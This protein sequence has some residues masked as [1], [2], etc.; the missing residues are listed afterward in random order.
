ME[1]ILVMSLSGSTMTLVYLLV[2][3]LL[4]KRIPARVHYLLAKIAV[5]YYLI[6]LP[7]LKSRY[8]EFFNAVMPG[9]QTVMR[10]IPLR[11]TNYFVRGEEKLYLNIYAKIQFVA[12]AV[13]LLVICYLL[14]GEIREYLHAIRRFVKY[15]NKDMTESQTAFVESL[16]EAYRIRRRI[17]VCQGENGESTMTFGIFRP[18]IFCGR[19]LETRE[20]E[21]L[22]RHELVH[23]K[24]RDVL[25]KILIRFAKLLHWWNPIMWALY[26]DFE[27]VSEWACDETVMADKSE[28]E[29]KEYLRL[30]I[31]ESRDDGEP[32]E[33][34]LRWRAGFGED[35]KQLMERM[36]NLMSRKK[37]NRIAAGMLVTVLAFANSMTVFAYRDTYQRELPDGTSQEEIEKTLNKDSIIFLPDEMSLEETP[38][39][40]ILEELEIVYDRQ[41]ID[42][43]GNIYPV[44]DEGSARLGCNHT[45]ESGTLVDHGKNADGSCEVRKFRAQM[46][47]KCNYT[48]QGDLIGTVT[49]NPCPH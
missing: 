23:I 15:A 4:R 9:R 28:T 41:F 40:T 3:Y 46:C 27:R 36:E 17:V 21:L 18:V 47:K 24:R 5:L 14:V 7:F 35:A 8:K 44:S 38:A 10:Q 39:D 31:E 19:P 1:Y 6:P 30:M 42:E 2:K 13:W 16:K 37:W 22:I 32:K 20:A 34:S 49:Y 12:V 11:W 29:V 48:I 45:F 25:W 43:E 33:V 26:R